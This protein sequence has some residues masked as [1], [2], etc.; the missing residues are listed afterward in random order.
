MP[1][2][3]KART[4]QH[5]AGRFILNTTVEEDGSALVSVVYITPD[6]AIQT[7]AHL[8]GHPDAGPGES[9]LNICDAYDSSNRLAIAPGGGRPGPI[10]G[11]GQD[12][13]A[14]VRSQGRALDGGRREVPEVRPDPRAPVYVN[15][16]RIHEPRP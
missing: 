6:G 3:Y 15:G 7:V 4:Q 2:R 9:V 10:D 12:P 1:A 14:F 13:T 16:C 5:S 11:V 8:S